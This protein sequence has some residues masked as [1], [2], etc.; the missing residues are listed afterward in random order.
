MSDTVDQGGKTTKPPARGM[1][2]AG[3]WARVFAACID[4]FWSTALAYL[5]LFG[6]VSPSTIVP[7]LS[8]WFGDPET[9]VRALHPALQCLGLGGLFLVVCEGVVLTSPGKLV[10]GRYR[11]LHRA[12][13]PSGRIRAVF[14]AAFKYLSVAIFLVPQA[15]AL[16]D[17]ERRTLYDRFTGTVVGRMNQSSS[18]R[19]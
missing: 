17:G 2:A 7:E 18:K 3:A 10:F 14:R 4:G 11:I 12:G 13:Q 6:P 15:W 19:T 1:I 9:L 16:V 8:I 5:L